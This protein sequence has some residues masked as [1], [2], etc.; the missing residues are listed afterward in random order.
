MNM[1]NCRF[2]KK[3]IQACYV[4]GAH[5]YAQKDQ[6]CADNVLDSVHGDFL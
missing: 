2:N 6:Q 5:C 4:Q 3:D 1:F